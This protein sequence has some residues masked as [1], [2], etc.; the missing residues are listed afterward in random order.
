MK[1]IFIFQNLLVLLLISCNSPR[2]K[3]SKDLRNAK[4]INI[5]INNDKK[6]NFSS[7]FKEFDI[8]P[9]QT[10]P[11]CYL[12]PIEEVFLLKKRI[13][14]KTNHAL[15]LFKKNG[16]FDKKIGDIGKGPGEHE[17]ISDINIDHD[18]EVI[19]FIDFY[20]LKLFQYSFDG[21]LINTK[22]LP[23]FVDAFIGF[24]DLY[25]FYTTDPN[26]ISTCKLNLYDPYSNTLI[27]KYFPINMHYNEY[28]NFWR[29][30][31]FYRFDNKISFV[32]NPFDTIYAINS[33]DVS[34]R[35]IINFGKNN[36]PLSFYEKEFS[37]IMDFSKKAAAN[38]YAYNIDKFYETTCYLL[39]QYK[40]KQQ[41]K[42]CIYNKKTQETASVKFFIDDVN[43]NSALI[44]KFIW[45]K[46]QDKNKLIFT[47]DPMV[48]KSIYKTK[49]NLK[50]KQM[51]ILETLA[52][53][54]KL[55]DNPVVIIGKLECK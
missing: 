8:V 51:T 2:N 25:Y 53:T 11:E 37:D 12:P 45:P 39:F 43:A 19:E 50:P 41:Y 32:I 42:R 38:N 17:Y 46:G 20:N 29:N 55:I 36:V 9:L 35:Y 24:K 33:N 15:F 28:L 44:K 30:T 52:D 18:K 13:L 26:D 7:I 54:M 5:D 27:Y 34:Y 1:I 23:F 6:I 14:I 21:K 48:L 22:K 10:K 47:L 49:S 4:I 40:Y 16:D 31:T 3:E